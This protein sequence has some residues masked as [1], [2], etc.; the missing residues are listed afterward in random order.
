MKCIYLTFVYAGKMI[1]NK[2]VLTNITWPEIISINIKNK[3]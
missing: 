3:K 2:V 1:E